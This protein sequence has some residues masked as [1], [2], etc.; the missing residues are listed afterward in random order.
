M[1][2]LSAVLDQKPFGKALEIAWDHTPLPVP[3][4]R[5]TR[6]FRDGRIMLLDL[7][8]RTQRVMFCGAYEPAETAVVRRLLRPGSTFVDAGAHVGWF[9]VLAARSVGPTGSVHAIEAFPSNAELLRANVANNHAENVTIH[10]C[11][12]ADEVGTLR[13][14]RQRGSDSGSITAGAGAAEAIVDVPA[15]TLDA[16]EIPSPVIDLL[17][18]DVEGL[19]ARVFSA[20]PHTLGRTQAVMVEINDGAL[21]RNGSSEQAL[22][23][24]LGDAGLTQVEDL[25]RVLDGVRNRV[26]PTYRNVLVRRPIKA[27]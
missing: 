14:G 10:H 13:V 3:R 15:S 2:A 18:I 11:A 20:A 17:K 7:A 27:S 1:S 21:Q 8:D 19:E 9:T 22:M 12:L 6:R 23:E 16:L 24:F 4:R 26:A 5:V 25:R